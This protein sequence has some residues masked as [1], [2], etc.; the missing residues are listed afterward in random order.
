MWEDGEVYSLPPTRFSRA[1]GSCVRMSATSSPLEIGPRSRSVFG[2]P[3]ASR[4][5]LRS[6]ARNNPPQ[7]QILVSETPRPVLLN[8]FALGFC[9]LPFQLLYPECFDFRV[10]GLVDG[11]HGQDV[12]PIDLVLLPDSLGPTIG[13]QFQYLI[14]QYEPVAGGY[15]LLLHLFQYCFQKSPNTWHQYLQMQYIVALGLRHGARRFL[16]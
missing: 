15:H 13:R 3:H 16:P 8:G 2:I 6:P 10:L 9:E 4:P 11:F 14:R 12:Q 7:Q 1:P 5:P